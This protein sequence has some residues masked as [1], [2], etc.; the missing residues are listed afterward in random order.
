MQLTQSYDKLKCLQLN[1]TDSTM[2]VC[3]HVYNLL[4]IN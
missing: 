3:A 4:D 2:Y 1:V